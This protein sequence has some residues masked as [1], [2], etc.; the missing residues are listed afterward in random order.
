MVGGHSDHIRLAAVGLRH[1]AESIRTALTG[2]PAH[3]FRAT[4]LALCAELYACAGR[5]ESHLRD[6]AATEACH[7]SLIESI[8]VAG[9]PRRENGSSTETL[10]A[11][12][13][14]GTYVLAVNAPRRQR[15]AL[16]EQAVGIVETI[17]AG[18]DPDDGPGLPY[19]VV[20]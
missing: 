3:G 13:D 9:E 11:S 2:W 6:I 15:V 18:L 19:S 7:V 17:T 14:I 5:V 8:T 4:G 16:L 12:L 1:A 10:V 20:E